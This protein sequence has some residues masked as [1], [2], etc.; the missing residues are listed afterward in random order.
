M[1]P[2]PIFLTWVLLGW[3]PATAGASTGP[4]SRLGSRTLLASAAG[5]VYRVHAHSARQRTYVCD[6]RSGRSHYLGDRLTFSGG[7]TDFVVGHY[8]LAGHYLG[9]SYDESGM[10]DYTT[11]RVM[12]IRTGR[13]RHNADG[14]TQLGTP[15]FNQK[16]GV[17]DLE[18]RPSG[19]VAWIARNIYVQ[20]MRLEVFKLDAQ[21]RTLLDA[22]SQIDP[23]SLAISG[24]RIYWT[25]GAQVQGAAFS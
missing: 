2:A 16:P 1:R 23:N 22:K 8:R 17:T 11:V 4:C 13:L 18:L 15:D 14:I 5:R 19:D 24:K 9:Y 21:G 6:V 7:G 12:D 25:T 20:P 3:M 10:E